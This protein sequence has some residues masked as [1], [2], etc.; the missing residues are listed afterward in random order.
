MSGNPQSLFS[1]RQHLTQGGLSVVKVTMGEP[2]RHA[3]VEARWRACNNAFR[4]EWKTRDWRIL[5]W[6]GLPGL[7]KHVGNSAIEIP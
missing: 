3:E 7:L 6:Q 4:G 1:K 5:C 2:G